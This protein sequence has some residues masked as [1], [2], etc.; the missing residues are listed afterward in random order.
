MQKVHFILLIITLTLL[1]LFGAGCSNNSPP[2]D[3]ETDYIT[4]TRAETL[5]TWG[6]VNIDTHFYLVENLP[7]NFPRRAIVD[8]TFVHNDKIFTYLTELGISGETVIST[9]LY[10]IGINPDSREITET[11]IQFSGHIRV[12]GLSI[13]DDDIIALFATNHLE[14]DEDAPYIPAFYA[15]HDFDGNELSKINFEALFNYSSGSINV[16]E[17]LFDVQDYLVISVMHNELQDFRSSIYL[18]NLESSEINVINRREETFFGHISI[19]PDNRVVL[20]DWSGQE[21]SLREI[22]VS[23]GKL[24]EVVAT[25]GRNVLQISDVGNNNPFDLMMVDDSFLFGYNIE[26]NTFTTLISWTEVGMQWFEYLGTMENGRVACLRRTWN[27]E[28]E[29]ELSLYILKPSERYAADG[30][31]TLTLAGVNIDTEFREVVSSFNRANARYKVIVED[32]SSTPFAPGG[33]DDFG[34]ELSR[35]QI[36]LI[37]GN[38]PDVIYD[39]SMALATT[40]ANQ[41]ML[42]N[43][44]PFIQ[45]DDLLSI[46]D[47]VP[48]FLSSL[49]HY[50]NSLYKIANT[51]LII[52][53]YST[54]EVL[55]DITIDDWTVEKLL[56]TFRNNNHTQYQYPLGFNVTPQWFV[57][58]MLSSDVDY[59]ISTSTFEANFENET[60]I[61]ILNTAKILYDAIERGIERERIDDIVDFGRG[62]IP[63]LYEIFS[64]AGFFMLMVN[65]VEEIIPIGFPTQHGGIHRVMQAEPTLSISSTTDHPEGAWE[66]IRFYLLNAG[67]GDNFRSLPL[68]RD[69]LETVIEENVV[70]LYGYDEDGSWGIDKISHGFIEFRDEVGFG[71]LVIPLAPRDYKPEAILRYLIENATPFTQTEF[72]LDELWFRVLADDLTPFFAG[73]RSAEE[74]ARVMQSRAQVFLAERQR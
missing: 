28:N 59:F 52:S 53:L 35:F 33:H 47:L 34:Q 21:L 31:I 62:K 69:L 48:S 56:E 7:V 13:T 9:T 18:V 12:G 16:L 40:M 32:H 27:E 49:Q 25:L 17:V 61:N 5:S 37:T 20:L 15:K 4:G 3:Q 65:S 22:K 1:A 72:L 71:G 24:G 68:R 41:G 67:S 2:T 73:S 11:T 63:I 74:T 58:F 55:G 30:R 26:E 14:E 50:D 6:D 43:L 8:G 23:E 39:S 45:D 64:G 60:F 29:Q 54:P 19:L 36:E 10:V 51:F 38:L 70:P 57:S 42:L 46:E 66:F 44:N